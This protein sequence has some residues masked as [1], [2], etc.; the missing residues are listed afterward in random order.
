[1][2]DGGTRSIREVMILFERAIDGLEVG[3]VNG[4]NESEYRRPSSHLIYIDAL[5]ALRRYSI[6][7]LLKIDI[8]KLIPHHGHRE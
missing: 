4:M 7:Q 8:F 6:L 3:D 1:M 2:I 5:R